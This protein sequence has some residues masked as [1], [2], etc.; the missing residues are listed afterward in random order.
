MQSSIAQKPVSEKSSSKDSLHV[1]DVKKETSNEIAAQAGIPKFIPQVSRS[2]AT[3]PAEVQRICDD[4]ENELVEESTQVQP[5]LTV[6]AVNDEY[7]QQADQVA[8]TV[9]RMPASSLAAS[10]N[11]E[12]ETPETGNIQ[13]KTNTPL[14]LQRMCAECEEEQNRSTTESR[15]QAKHD[16][17]TG[18]QAGNQV[19]KTIGSPSVGAALSG[20]IKSRVEPVLGRNLSHVRVHQNDDAQRAAASINAKAFTHQNH[21]YLGKGESDQNLGLMAHEA[22]HVVQQGSGNLAPAI[23]KRPVDFQV[24]GRHPDSASFSKIAFYDYASS[25]LHP[26][27]RAKVDAMALPADRDL[28]LRGFA[29]EEG[30]AAGNSALIGRRMNSVKNRLVDEGHEAAKISPSPRLSDGVNQI[31]YRR[32]RSVEMVE[33][34]S[35]AIT[36]ECATQPEFEVP[37]PAAKMSRIQTGINRSRDMITTSITR[38]GNPAGF[39]HAQTLLHR[40]FTG[41]ATADVITGLSTIRTQLSTYSANTPQCATTCHSDCKDTTAYNNPEVTPD[42]M[43]ICPGFHTSAD[44]DYAAVTLLH[45]ASH[46]APGM[47]SSDHA[48]EWDRLLD[49]LNATESLDNADSYT[50]LVYLIHHPGTRSIGPATDDTTNITDAGELAQIEP[51][52][53]RVGQWVS[54]TGSETQSL[55]SEIRDARNAGAWTNSWYEEVMTLAA[56][57][58]PLTSPPTTPV[59]RDQENVAAIYDRF[60]TM[61]NAMGQVLDIR[62]R[63]GSVA[64]WQAG[65]GAI[66]RV[67]PTFFGRSQ[68]EQIEI[69]LAALTRATPNISTAYHSKYVAYTKEIRTKNSLGP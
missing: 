44:T 46:A 19:S 20:S 63:N 16:S 12:D 11:G 55:Y 56:N 4:C 67:G 6:G 61:S 24:R 14:Y 50:M 49:L 62:K 34:G 39:P 31:D 32:W 30:D 3:P 22:T 9:M 58:Y 26:T 45:E 48:Y 59:M 8:D 41:A 25:W 40:L 37:C 5:K 10:G 21:I 17:G 38:I 47:Q 36:P 54:L 66:V 23:Q 13:R 60:N 33:T 69:L 43:V 35:P 7:E 42:A 1:N 51:A 28:E 64:H 57:H 2:V 18:G 68:V 65:P 53:A 29:S 15:V 52:I 27:E